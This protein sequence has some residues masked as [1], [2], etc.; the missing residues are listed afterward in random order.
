MKLFVRGVA[1]FGI[2]L[3]LAGCVVAPPPRP[4]V[5][6]YRPPPPRY[7]APPPPRYYPPPPPRYYAPPRPVY[8]AP[9]VTVGVHIN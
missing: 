1:S 5:A 2:A 8:P 9:G 7:Y 6:Y 3:A 4:P